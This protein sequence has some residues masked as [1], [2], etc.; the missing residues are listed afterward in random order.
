MSHKKTLSIG[1]GHFLFKGCLVVFFIFIQNLKEHFVSKQWRPWVCTVSLYI[2]Q[3]GHY[4]FTVKPV[5][6]GHLTID[7]TKVLVENGSFMKVESIAECSLQNALLSILQY[8][9]PAL[10]DNWY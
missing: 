5:L 8:F 4:A 10:S 2:Q 9:L 1:P 3:K 6:N 7:K